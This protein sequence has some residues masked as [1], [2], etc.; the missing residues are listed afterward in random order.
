MNET[1]KLAAVGVGLGL[2]VVVA[3]LVVGRRTLQAVQENAYLVN[4]IDDR[5]LAYS[6]VNAIGESVTGDKDFSLGVWL[7]EKLNPG[8][9]AKENDLLAGTQESGSPYGIA[10]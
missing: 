1:V 2:V 3:A 4:P 10:P 6:G 9:V 7:W 8:A 5:N